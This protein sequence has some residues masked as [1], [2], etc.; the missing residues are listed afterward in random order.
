MATD[1]STSAPGEE[2]RPID[3]P[4]PPRKRR[5]G[6][7]II[8]IVV[9]VL[10]LIFGIPRVIHAMRVVSTDDAKGYNSSWTVGTAAG[11]EFAGKSKITGGEFVATFSAI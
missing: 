4:A 5:I 3:P 8:A 1:V 10:L 6:R 11:T 9:V 7:L 2:P